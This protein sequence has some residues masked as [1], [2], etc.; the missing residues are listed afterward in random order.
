MRN[1]RFENFNRQRDIPVLQG[2]AVF[3]VEAFASDL[4]ETHSRNILL[5]SGL[6]KNPNKTGCSDWQCIGIWM[7][8]KSLIFEIFRVE[9]TNT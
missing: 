6:M 4:S 7:A 5:K 2:P 9:L 8:L 3:E 1:D